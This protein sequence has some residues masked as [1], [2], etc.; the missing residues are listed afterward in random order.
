MSHNI[1]Y[2]NDAAASPKQLRTSKIQIP[3]EDR[4]VKKAF[5]CK[6]TKTS[7]ARHRGERI[8]IC[9]RTG[10]H[11][12]ARMFQNDPPHTDNKKGSK[13]RVFGRRMLPWKPLTFRIVKLNISSCFVGQIPSDNVKTCSGYLPYSA[14]AL[15][16]QDDCSSIGFMHIK[17]AKYARLQ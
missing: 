8:R 12:P 6:L 4:I 16:Y 9:A 5:C 1:L 3:C 11:R 7:P 14:F 17:P 13:I 10:L 2:C 15:A